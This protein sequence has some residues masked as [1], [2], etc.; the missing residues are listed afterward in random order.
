M[1]RGV[2]ADFSSTSVLG[3]LEGQLRGVFDVMIKRDTVAGL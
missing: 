3:S 1:R 2:A